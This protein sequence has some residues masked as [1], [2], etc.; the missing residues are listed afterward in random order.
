M[1]Q[2]KNLTTDQ[3]ISFLQEERDILIPFYTTREQIDEV[4]KAQ[5]T[6]DE[7]LRECE[8]IQEVFG[9]HLEMNLLDE[10]SYVADQEEM[11]IE[12][13]SYIATTPRRIYQEIVP[14]DEENSVDLTLS[15]TNLKVIYNILIDT[16]F[17]TAQKIAQDIVQTLK[18]YS[19]DKESQGLPF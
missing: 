12:A 13:T 14:E 9:V 8:N 7:W 19:F 5:L 3:I 1:T 15:A 18:D 2:F 4:M 11:V 17:E 16:P 10:L 6:N